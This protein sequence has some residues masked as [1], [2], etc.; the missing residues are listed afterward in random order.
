MPVALRLAAFYLAYFAYIGAFTPYFPVYL[1]GRGL[2]STEIAAVLSMPQ[3]A[4]IFA[5]AFWGWLADRTGAWRAVVV[6]SCFALA[7]GFAAMPFVPGFAGIT[8]LVAA[9]SIVSA[10]GLPLVEAI[11]LS[12]L[13]GRSGHYGPIRLW[14][15]VGFIV[16]VLL[17]GIWLDHHGSD[18]LPAIFLALALAALVASAALPVGGAAPRP[19]ADTVSPPGHTTAAVRALIGAGFCMAVAHGALYA[20]FTLHLQRLGYSGKAI[21]ALWTLGVLAEIAVFFWLPALFRRFSLSAILVASLLAAVLRFAAIGWAAGYLGVLLVAQLLHAATFG[22]FH[23]ASVAAVHR[24]YPPAAHARGQAMFSSLAY[25]GGGA[26]G[27]L[28]AGWAWE[29]GGPGLTF[30][31]AAAS[32]A[33]GAALTVWLRPLRLYEPSRMR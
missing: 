25:G 13:A 26:A 2:G 28:L 31:L 3:L 19:S 1:A 20:F 10:G 32:A 17:V 21:G 6:A 7:A 4:R 18:S 16:T 11:T 24:L 27:A 23:A 33:A 15:S 22:A 30:S 9:T 12:A 8:A 29:V 14:G 5:P